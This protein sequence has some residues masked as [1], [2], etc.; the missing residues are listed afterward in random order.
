[1][2]KIGI[3]FTTRNNYNMFENWLE[4]VDYEGFNIL[5]IDEDSTEEN[6]KIGKDLCEKH[7]V[8]YLDREKRGFINNVTTAQKYFKTLDINWGFW[9]HHDC[10]PLTDKFFT[11][12]NNLIVSEKLNE[13]GM[14]GFNTYHRRNT[15]TKYESGGRE[16]EFTARAPLE[17]GDNWYRNKRQWGNCRPDLSSGKFDKPFAIESV[18]FGVLLSFDMWEKHI[19]V[20][21]DFVFYM[22]TDDI[23]FQFLYHNV[24]NLCIPYLT[25]GH[26]FQS[27]GN[28]GIPISSPKGT[29]QERDHFFGEESDQ[30]AISNLIE[31]WGWDY[32]DI[33]TFEPIKEHF[34]GTLFWEFY[35]HDP[36]NG[37]LRSFD[38]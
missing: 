20:T 25:L 11:K 17:P 15:I 7:G 31:R 29:D 19:E 9:S 6:K 28:F 14:V 34:K 33:N 13:F 18:G 36:I 1:M 35:H 37:P 5:N 21:D 2:K 27:K 32:R 38:I 3:F 30:Q 26:A 16:L 4:T 8:K 24:Y 10:W 22:S 23:A 12:L